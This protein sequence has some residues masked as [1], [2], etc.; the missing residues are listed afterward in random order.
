MH[1]D[2]SLNF[3]VQSKANRCAARLCCNIVSECDVCNLHKDKP[4]KLILRWVGIAKKSITFASNGNCVESTELTSESNS[5]EVILDAASCFGSGYNLPTNIYFEVDGSRQCLHASCSQPLNLG[6]A[7]YKDENKGFLVLVGFQAMSGRTHNACRAPCKNQCSCNSAQT[8]FHQFRKKDYR[9]VCEAAIPELDE[10]VTRV[11][12][13]SDACSPPGCPH[14]DG[15]KIDVCPCQEKE[16]CFD[17]KSC[18]PSTECPCKSVDCPS[19]SRTFAKTSLR[20]S[21]DITLP[22][23]TSVSGVPLRVNS[24]GSIQYVWSP[25]RGSLLTDGFEYSGISCNGEK[26]KGKVVVQLDVAVVTVAPGG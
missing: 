12:I 24:D 3:T 1:F 16:Q 9:L 13:S 2:T 22:K 14:A 23:P 5:N 11:H 10:A 26:V 21:A 25:S 20:C 17:G 8:C 15:F 19:W 6:D 7:I 4:Q 18:K